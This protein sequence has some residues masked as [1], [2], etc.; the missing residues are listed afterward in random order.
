MSEAITHAAAYDLIDRFL[1][2]NL[3]DDDYA[4]YSEALEALSQSAPSPQ[5]AVPVVPEKRTVDPRGIVETADSGYVDGWNACIDAILALRPAVEPMTPEQVGKACY[6][7]QDK[8]G[9]EP[10][11]VDGIAAAEAHHFGFDR[12]AQLE[13]K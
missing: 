11:F 10:T 7:A 4:K 3:H 13:A 2:N 9:H 8:K 6:L 5:P 1:R 12:I